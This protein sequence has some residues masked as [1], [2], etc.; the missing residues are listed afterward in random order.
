MAKLDGVSWNLVSE[1]F[2]EETPPINV[3]THIGMFVAWAIHHDLWVQFPGIDGSCA[4]QQV[5]NREKTGRTFVPEPV[6]KPW[7]KFR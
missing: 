5:R 2:P 6:T 3:A 1:E 7:W 4:M